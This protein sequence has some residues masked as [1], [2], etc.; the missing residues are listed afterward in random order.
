MNFLKDFD[1]NKKRVLVRCDFNVPL[2]PEGKILDDFRIRETIPTIE[3]LIKKEAKVILMSHLGKPEGKI[4]ENLRLDKVQE[5]LIE[6]LDLSIVKAPD[7]IGKEI[8][9]WV[10][11]M[12]L[13]EILLLENLRF[14]KEEEKNDE[15]F[16]K[17]LAKLGDIYINEAFACSHRFHASI[18]GVPKY[19]PS[20]AGFLLEKEINSLN[21]ITENPKTPLVAIFGGREADFKAIEKISN[22]ADWILVGELVGKEIEKDNTKLKYPEKVIKPVDGVDGGRDIGPKTLKLFKEKILRAKTIFWSGPLG[23]IEE[24]R[25]QK[26]TKEV[27]KA[28]IE[29]GA[30]SVIGGGETIEFINKLGFIDRFSHVS[31]GGSAM[32]SYLA[33]EKLPGI[34]ALHSAS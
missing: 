26:G 8:E 7:C 5:K 6:Y 17:A 30:F 21:K 4:V 20:G 13:G 12:T 10:L 29:S 19:L 15:N 24:E 22:T 25:F 14:H 28:I 34:E 27:A 1:L 3:Y 31:T 18:V 9:N 2:S 11:E 33:G 32:L 23:K 16:A